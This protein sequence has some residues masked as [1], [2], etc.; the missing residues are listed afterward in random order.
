MKSRQ[1]TKRGPGRVHSRLTKRRGD[2]AF[3]DEH[4][5]PKLLRVY[6]NRHG[7]DV[8][9]IVQTDLQVKSRAAAKAAKQ[10]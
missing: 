3:A 7:V 10:Y 6:A 2:K 4:H 5:I 1:Q 9:T 8:L